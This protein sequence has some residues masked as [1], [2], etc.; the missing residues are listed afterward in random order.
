VLNHPLV[1]RLAV[2]KVL[3]AV[4]SLWQRAE[5]AADWCPGEALNAKTSAHHAVSVGSKL[6]IFPHKDWKKWD[7]ALS[8]RITLY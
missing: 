3:D 2:R 1:F 7:Q 5:R 8:I 4:D 6:L